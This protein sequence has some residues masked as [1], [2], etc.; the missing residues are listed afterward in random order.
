MTARAIVFD[1]F[2]TLVRFNVRVP[3]L[4]LQ[5]TEWRSTM[6]WL[7]DAFRRELG[8]ADFD[9]FL[10]AIAEETAELIRARPP[11]HL[12]VPSRLRFER[13]LLRLGLPPEVAAAHAGPLSLAHMTHLASSVELPEGHIDLL[14]ALAPRFR[15][16]VVSNFDHG[17]TARGI[18]DR[19]GLSRFFEVILISEEVGR[20]KPH[21][22]IFVRA[23]GMLGVSAADAVYVGDSPTDD[24]SGGKAA[25]MR[26]VW[27]NPAERELP[28]GAPMPDATVRS[29]PQLLDLVG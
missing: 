4:R 1:L 12:E 2:G 28:A 6:P 3:T 23:L 18:L 10:R 16:A 5:G 11:E 20:R 9:G 25:G 14:E 26:V 27:V 24:I 22:A 13:A 29:L 7:V 15:L 21:P 17:E 19:F 8:D